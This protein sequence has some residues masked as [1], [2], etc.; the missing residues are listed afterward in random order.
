M[1]IGEGNEDTFFTANR[2]GERHFYVNGKEVSEKSWEKFM[3]LEEKEWAKERKERQNLPKVHNF[4][5]IDR[6]GRMA[7][8]NH[9]KGTECPTLT[10]DATKP[11]YVD[12]KADMERIAAS[13]GQE[14]VSVDDGYEGWQDTARTFKKE[15]HRD[16]VIDDD[17]A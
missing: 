10:T 12:S 7:L 15:N 2:W 1:R 16:D 8:A 14:V 4:N 9:G 3:S 11:V 6:D 17:F 5:F 13:M